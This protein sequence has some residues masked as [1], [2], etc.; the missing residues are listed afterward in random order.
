[1]SCYS[2][3]SFPLVCSLLLALGCGQSATEPPAS[4]AA[5]SKFQLASEPEG[6]LEVLDAKDQA[7]DGE[8]VVVVGRVGGGVNPWVDGRAAFLM[9]DTRVRPS[10]D[11]EAH[12]TSD[13]AGCAK[14][15]LEAST[16]VKFLG[17]DG[18]VLPVDARKLL[19]VEEQAT[20]IV[21]GVTS[22]DKTGNLSI[23]AEGIFVRR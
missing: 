14:E 8:P 12:C 13:C 11:E 17:H 23:A 2:C 1:M 15:M 22:R 21:Q 20:I 18:K 3:L 6:A 16:M 7:K 19:G 4:V 10:C 9:I 5:P